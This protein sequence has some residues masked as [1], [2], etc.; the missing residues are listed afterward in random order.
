MCT[1]QTVSHIFYIFFIPSS[2]PPPHPSTTPTLSRCTL[3]ISSIEFFFNTS[4]KIQSGYKKSCYPLKNVCLLI[5]A[6]FPAR[7]N[8][9][10]FETMIYFALVSESSSS[11]V[12]I[13]DV[14]PPPPPL[15]SNTP[16]PPTSNTPLPPIPPLHPQ[17]N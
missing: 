1:L 6:E 12:K 9:G 4:K 17:G 16:L 8:S 2:P 14:P 10:T 3:V 11:D 5:R 15:P 7:R 13:P